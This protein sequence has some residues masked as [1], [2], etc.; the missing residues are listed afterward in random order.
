MA[1]KLS[2]ED[3][4]RLRQALGS[5]EGW[6]PVPK[7][8]PEVI[9]QLGGDSN[10]SFVVSDGLMRWVL[11][12]N[13]PRSDLGINR[14]NERLALQAAHVVG[15]SPLP[16][17][18]SNEVLVT[19]FITGQQ[20]RLENLLQIGALFGQI[21]SLVIELAPID[22]KQH[23]KNYY[24]KVTPEPLLK[25]CYQHIVDLYPE[26]S[27]NL[28]PCH[29]D[30]L[31]P[32]MIESQHG[33]YIIDWEYAAAADPA[34]DLAVFSS[35][36]KLNQAQLRSLLSAYD[37]DNV[38]DTE[39]LVSRIEYYEKYYRLIEILWWNMRGRSPGIELEAL[40]EGLV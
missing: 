4:S 36:Y 34:Y 32:N 12:L 15:I 14:D 10:L 22:L 27:V 21:H 20:A 18:D 7:K 5:W 19:P 11:R 3:R 13:N 37:P 24:E 29:N 35:T 8:Q 33:F 39:S 6:R 40:A 9:T 26:G 1:K 25:D 16:N 30:C 17:F 2:A 38:L 31:L 23:L 28:K